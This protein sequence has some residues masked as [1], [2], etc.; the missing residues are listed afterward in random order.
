MQFK[1]QSQLEKHL[2]T[3]VNNVILNE[4]FETIVDIWLRKQQENV[5]DVYDPM[6]YERRHSEGGL[7][8]RS[9]IIIDT[10]PFKNGAHYVLENITTGAGDIIGDKINELIEGET[11]FAG[12]PK[13]DMPP[14]PYT[15]ET[16]EIINSHPSEIK[17]AFRK[18]FSRNGVQIDIT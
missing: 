2:N 16:V 3:V 18:G 4:V 8:D 1:N 7:A 6:N 17:D 12:D 15:Q 14:R 13:T 5:Y 11:G 9:N 10:Q